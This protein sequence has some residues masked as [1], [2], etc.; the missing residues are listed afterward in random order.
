[1]SL[2]AIVLI[3]LSAFM[4]VGWNLIS[5]R[6]HPS[7]AFFLI[8]SIVG[9]LMFAP[10]LVLYRDTLLHHIPDRVWILLVTTG[11][12]M[13]LYYAALAGAYRAGDMSIAYPLARSA[14]VILV[15]V[16]TVLLGRG[17]QVSLTFVI[18]SILVVIGCFLIPLQRFGDLHWRHYLSKICVLALLAAI[19]TTG[20]SLVDDQ[21]LRV[22]RAQT[23]G[24]V[25]NTQVTLLYACLE[26][27]FVSLWLAFF[28][29]LRRE[30][31]QRLAHVLRNSMGTAVLAGVIIHLG[32][33]LVLIAMAFSENVS[34]V[35]GFR[36]LSIPLGA[37]VGI[38]VLK[39]AAPVP[40]LTGVAIMFAGLVL[41]AVG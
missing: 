21:A 26:A 3:L 33:A 30:S 7:A 15:A 6:Q 4:H 11:F 23:H 14:P 39:E 2:F 36:Q 40:K 9:A 27:V 10:T 41:V 1:M 37:I 32:Y 31:R 34:Y 13:A 17:N 20:Y 25:G 22:L 18:G 38:L 24:T 12:F 8:A 19:G 16:V 5:K 28:I 29:A 35:V